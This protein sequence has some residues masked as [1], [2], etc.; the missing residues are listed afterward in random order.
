M[1]DALRP[2]KDQPPAQDAST[3]DGHQAV[4]QLIEKEEREVKVSTFMSE[5]SHATSGHYLW[6]Q[7]YIIHRPWCFTQ[8]PWKGNQI[9]QGT[10]YGKRFNPWFQF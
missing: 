9:D 5:Y 10:L 8:R 2:A 7:K 3:S 6:S 4:C 1:L